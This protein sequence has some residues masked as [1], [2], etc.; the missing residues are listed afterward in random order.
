MVPLL[1]L[2]GRLGLGRDEVVL[3]IVEDVVVLDEVVV[4][5]VDLVLRLWPP[6]IAH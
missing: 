3:R 5:D 4:W 1:S 2:P 6:I